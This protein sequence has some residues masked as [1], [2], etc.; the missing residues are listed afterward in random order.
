MALYELLNKEAETEV[1][2][3]Y[4]KA[5][6]SY[7]SLLT[8]AY[9]HVSPNRAY[10]THRTIV[11]AIGRS[12]RRRDDRQLVARLNMLNWSTVVYTRGDR[13]GDRSVYTPSNDASIRHND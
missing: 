4:C 3:N 10:S 13:R 2:R 12:D 11:A 5:N 9:L 6:R 8:A 1:F 7:T